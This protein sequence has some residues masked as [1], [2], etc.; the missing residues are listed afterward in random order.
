MQHTNKIPILCT[1]AL[2]RQ[3]IKTAEEKGFQIDVVPFIK[4]EPLQSDELTKVIRAFSAQSI[5]AIFTSMNAAEAVIKELNGVKPLWT[6]FCIGSATRDTLVQYFGEGAIT[7][8]ADNASYLAHTIVQTGTC[9][10]AVFFCGDQRMNELPL[11]LSEGKIK[12]REVIMYRTI[13]VD[14]KI[15]QSYQGVLFFSPSA[16]KSFFSNN[17]IDPQ[18]VLF[19]IG[20]TT[21]GA[22]KKHTSN[23]V[24][25]SSE[26]GKESLVK[27]MIAFYEARRHKKVMN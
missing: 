7:G 2:S 15:S 13:L 4:I 25:T 16:V 5:T 1:R 8:V 26:A 24:V 11:I 18:T 19:A 21:A 6:L 22:I 10:E 3:L 23:L 12:V 27:T 9:N 20:Q 14:N 17:V